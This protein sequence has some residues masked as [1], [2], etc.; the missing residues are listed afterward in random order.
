MSIETASQTERC[1]ITAQGRSFLVERLARQYAA[2]ARLVAA[3]TPLSA[4]PPPRPS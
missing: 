2:S 4:T 1:R 3:P